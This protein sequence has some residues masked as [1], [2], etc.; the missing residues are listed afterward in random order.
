MVE[1]VLKNLLTNAIEHTPEHGALGMRLQAAG[2]QGRPGWALQVW[3]SGPGLAPAVAHALFTPFVTGG[4]EGGGLG[5]AICR[6]LAQ[7]CGG[8]L[9]VVNA[10]APEKGVRAR[11][12]LPVAYGT[13][14]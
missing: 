2:Q 11:L 14:P 6:D 4:G 9:E 8:S 3:D 7:A 5:L 12:W 10:T 13:P 1:E